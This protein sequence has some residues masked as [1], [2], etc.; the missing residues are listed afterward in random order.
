[1][2]GAL[3]REMGLSREQALLT[4]SELRAVTAQ[5]V[6]DVRLEWGDRFGELGRSPADGTGA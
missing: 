1:M 6:G 5:G 2:T 3:P 4:L